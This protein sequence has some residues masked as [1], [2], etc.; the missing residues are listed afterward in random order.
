MATTRKNATSKKSLNGAYRKIGN[1]MGKKFFGNTVGMTNNVNGIRG[2]RKTR[3]D[4]FKNIKSDFEEKG[5][6]GLGRP[7]DESLIKGI[8]EKFQKLIEDDEHSVV[9]NEFEGKVYMRN[10]K[11]PETDIP[12]IENLLTEDIIKKLQEYYHGYFR[13]NRIQ[14][15]RNYG[16]S[17][18][19]DSRKELLSN[20]WHCDHRI[21]YY[22]K[23]FV[24]L[25]DVTQEDGPF[26]VMS[27]KRTKELMDKGFKSRWDY[28]LDV[29][30]MEDEKYVFRGI[31]EIGT[32]YIANP[33]LCLHRAGTPKENRYR[34]MLQFRF[35][36]SDKPISK[37]WMKDVP[38]W[39]NANAMD[40]MA[41]GIN[42]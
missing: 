31:G 15:W 42:D 27:R 20:R 36:P 23:L 9:S 38:N 41:K 17:E 21:T 26:H 1:I 6:V 19:V 28:N 40:S 24:N 7:Y 22:T 2:V 37:N 18:E 30:E 3:K 33:Q 12:E 4:E 29:N 13:V 8:K 35:E 32:A 5:Y 10:L 11:S 14:T 39:N 25:S 34:D 16:V